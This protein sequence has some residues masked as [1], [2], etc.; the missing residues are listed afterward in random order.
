[1]FRI[2]GKNGR[3]FTEADEGAFLMKATILLFGAVT[4]ALTPSFASA[5]KTSPP[6]NG[7]YNGSG[8]WHTNGPTTTG[9]PGADCEAVIAS[10]GSSPGKAADNGNSAFLGSAGDVYAGS[11]PQNSRNTASVSQYDV[12]CANQPG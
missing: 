2:V 3:A 9:Q 5:Q 10:G 1:V 12:A 7:Q 6:G 8:Y 4:L 11:Q